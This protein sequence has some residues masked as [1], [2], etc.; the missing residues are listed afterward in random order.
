MFLYAFG[1]TV[2]PVNLIVAYGLASVLAALPLTP[3][4][5]VARAALLPARAAWAPPACSVARGG[6]I[7]HLPLGAG[8]VEIGKPLP[9]VFDARRETLRRLEQGLLRRLLAGRV[10]ALAVRVVAIARPRL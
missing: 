10:A 3:G 9:G 4:G 7:G 2:N 6:G 5:N 8:E 1:A